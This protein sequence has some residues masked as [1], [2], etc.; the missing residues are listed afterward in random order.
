MANPIT[1][2]AVLTLANT[3]NAGGSAAIFLPNPSQAQPGDRLVSAVILSGTPPAQFSIG[4]DIMAQGVLNGPVQVIPSLV[5]FSP[6]GGFVTQG[7]GWNFAGVT[8]LALF[9]RP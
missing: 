6:S 8:V 5:N 2:G 3:Q 1:Y 9:E 4:S 7:F